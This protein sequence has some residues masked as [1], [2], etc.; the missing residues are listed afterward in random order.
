MKHTNY[1]LGIIG[2]A[3]GL[4]CCVGSVFASEAEKKFSEP[5]PQ[6]Q[7]EAKE[8]RGWT[9]MVHPELIGEHRDLGDRAL[10]L[11]DSKLLDICRMVPE[12]ALSKLKEVPIYLED[13]CP[14]CKA[15]CF[16][17]NVQWL[18][19]NGHIAEKEKT[20][21]LCNAEYFI[22][23]IETQP[24]MVLHELAHAYHNRCLEDGFS[25]KVVK[26]AFDHAME[27]KQYEKVLHYRGREIKA[28]ATTN[29]MEYFAEISESWFGTNDFY[30]FVR[31]E[32]IKH[33]PQGALMLCKVW[34]NEVPDLLKKTLETTE[35][36]Q[37]QDE[38]S[39]ICDCEKELNMPVCAA[40]EPEAEKSP[41]EEL[42]WPDGAPGALGDEEKD[43]PKLIWSLPP[44]E[45]ATGAA[46]VVCPGG[47]YGH[48][49]MGHEGADIIRW[50]NSIGVAAFVVD[51]RHSGKGY[52]HPAPLQD[53]QRAIRT[54]RSRAD[55]F[56]IQSDHIGVMGFS[57]G[58]HLASTAGTHFDAGDPDATDPIAKL[59]CRPDFMILCYAVIAFGEDCTHYGSQYNL[60]GKDAP[61]E[62]IRQFSNEKQ[63]TEN[64]PPTFLW[65][66]DEDTVV[67]S[68]NSV[69]FYLACREKGVP[70]EMHIFR[71]GR[72][73]IGLAP[74]F[75]GNDQWPELCRSW[76]KNM[77]FLTVD[78]K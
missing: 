7:Y 14:V 63:V 12:P 56:G 59:S 54:V 77:G 4:C 8:V 45:I 2:L 26:A 72:H 48:L 42:L 46:V 3:L 35:N 10:D 34:G 66:T 21:E 36:N 22:R 47:G 57:A 41:T 44:K 31:V 38:I 23:T 70:A 16:H 9:V 78:E 71:K 24:S 43:C 6:D 37:Q 65:H 58:G 55:E 40:A 73:G 33:D 39:T 76:M 28:Y 29:Q 11:L 49:A 20:V 5:T 62:L 60:L 53:V 52:S 74:G 32:L 17:P 75:E 19:A 27:S 50:L 67:P 69:K 18:T 13:D 51:Y 1:V 64:T 25:N 61:E 30:P 15:A 68:E